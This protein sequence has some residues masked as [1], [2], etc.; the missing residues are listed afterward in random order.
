MSSI[1]SYWAQIPPQAFNYSAVARNA[2]GQPIVSSTIGIQISILK[3]TTIGQV[4]YGENH[5]VN[6]DQYGLFNLIIGAGAIQ[7]GSMNSIDWSTD[8]YFLKVGMDANGGTNFLTMGTTQLLSVPYALHSKTAESLVGGG[9]GF[10]GDYNDLTNAPTNVSVF[11][12]DIGYV[13]TL[14]DDDP[15]NEL[16]Q[17]SFSSTGDTLYLSNG[18]WVIIPGLS[19]ANTPPQLATLTTIAINNIA[20][21]SASSGGNITDDG[22]APIT[23]RGVCWSTSPNP[24]TSNNV[25]ND[26]TGTGLYFSYLSVLTGNTTYYVRA[27]AINSAGTA[28]GNEF[29]FTTPAGGIVSNPGSGVTFDGYTYSSI[30][31]GNGQE[32]MSENLRTTVYSNGDPIPNVTVGSTWGGLTTGAWAYYNNDSQYNNPYGKLY[33]SY[34]VIDSRNVCPTG[35]HVPSDAEITALVNYLGG[36]PTAALKL[37][38]TGT[39]WPNNTNITNQSGFNALPSGFRDS[40]NSSVF[41]GLTS[42]ASYWGITANGPGFQGTLEMYDGDDFTQQVGKVL[43]NGYSVRCIKN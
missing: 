19:A 9:T 20:F 13:T 12:N 41:N 1:S 7:S 16:Q 24:T 18:N 6:T 28:Y 14:N 3:S 5:F 17:F 29:S 38:A 4:M 33:N 2:A 30:V 21:A 8:N 36:A 39:A 10:S 27:Y 31:L 42:Y 34:T 32:W 35:W 40:Q 26:F 11:N 15:S 37:K 23:Q 43:N 25:T 22:G